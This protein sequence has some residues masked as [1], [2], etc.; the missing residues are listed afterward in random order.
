MA[1]ETPSVDTIFCAAV[2]IESA[3]ERCAYI[4]QACR[5]DAD[6]RARV[7]KLVDAH[8]RAGGFMQSPAGVLAAPQLGEGGQGVATVDQPITECPGT[9]IGPYKLLEQIGEGGF[10]VVF[11]AEQQA[12]I[13]RKVALKVIKPDMDSGR[14]G[15]A[16]RSPHQALEKSSTP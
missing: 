7:E 15:S 14:C 4:A 1:T 6:F 13:R 11:M 10:G 2:E 3:E 9:V 8:F 12:P 5:D 16:K